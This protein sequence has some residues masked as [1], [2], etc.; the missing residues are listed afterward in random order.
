MKKLYIKPCIDE[1]DV[2]FEGNMMDTS[3]KDLVVNGDGVSA[4][5]ALTNHRRGVWGNLWYDGSEAE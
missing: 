5:D 3:P 1:M 4:D 2:M